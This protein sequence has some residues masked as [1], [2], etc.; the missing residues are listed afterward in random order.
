MAG[1][2]WVPAA[3]PIREDMS[4]GE[5]RRVARRETD[6]RVAC[7][8]LAIANALDGLSRERAAKQAGIDRQALR[9]WVIRFNAEGIAGLR[10]RPRSGR[11]P[12]LDEGQL[13]VLR[14][15]VLRGPDIERDGVSSW[16]AKDLCRLVEARFGVR[17]QESGMLKLLHSLDLSWQKTRPCHPCADAKAQA[18]F[19][20][21]SRP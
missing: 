7:R 14:A 20:K 4:S 15:M 18:A 12:F 9:D 13:A 11:P 6:G 17:Y 3:I 16:T 1:G 8:L 19:K 10:D 2:R 5:L 21:T